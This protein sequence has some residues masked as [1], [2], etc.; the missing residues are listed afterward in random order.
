MNNII[1][2]S[3]SP[4]FESFIHF[5]KK[6][7][8]M[9]LEYKVQLNQQLVCYLSLSPLQFFFFIWNGNWS[10]TYILFNEGSLYHKT[11]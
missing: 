2:A 8:F 6:E 3:L 7:Y 9:S 1:S 4:F 5:N 10:G 11:A